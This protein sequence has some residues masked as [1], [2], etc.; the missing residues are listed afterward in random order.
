MGTPKKKVVRALQVS[1]L[2]LPAEDTPFLKVLEDF[3][4]PYDTAICPPIYSCFFWVLKKEK[5]C[6][7]L[8]FLHFAGLAFLL[9]TVTFMGLTIPGKETANTAA[10]TPDTTTK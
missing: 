5:K 3:F 6:F 1:S 4:A 7:L 2:H 8:L 9:L 10:V